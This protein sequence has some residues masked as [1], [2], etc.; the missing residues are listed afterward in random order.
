MQPSHAQTRCLSCPRSG[1]NCDNPEAVEVQSGFYIAANTSL[2]INATSVVVWQCAQHRSCLG[3]LAHGDHSC[4]PGHSGPLCGTCTA[5]FYRGLLRCEPCET[6]ANESRLGTRNSFILA[7]LAWLVGALSA[8]QYLRNDG[9]SGSRPCCTL[10]CGTCDRAVLRLR[11]LLR[12]IGQRMISGAGLVRIGVGYCQTVGV[13]RR[14][15]RVQWPRQFFAFLQALDK[16]SP[17][18]VSL[19]P[20]ECVADRSINFLMQLIATL[21]MPILSMLLLALLGMVVA[22]G[23]GRWHPR[24]GPC[25]LMVAL[26][27]WPQVWDLASWAVLL[28]YPTIAR[29]TVQAF[30]CIP[31]EDDWLLRSDPTLSCRTAEWYLSAAMAALGIA[32]YCIGIPLMAMLVARRQIRQGSNRSARRRLVHV[33]TRSYRDEVAWFME[34]VDLLRKFLL[35]GVIH[36]VAPNSRLQLVFGAVVGLFFLLLDQEL[37]PFKSQSCGTV[38]TAAHL[39]LLFTYMVAHL[40][41]V[42][43]QETQA[44]LPSSIRSDT[45][46]FLIIAANSGSF[47]LILLACTRGLT[48]ITTELTGEQLVFNDGTPVDLLPPQE[49]SGYHLF[50]SHVWAHGQDVAASLKSSLRGMLPSSSIFL[51]VVH[52]GL[53]AVT[54]SSTI[55]LSLHPALL[56]HYLLKSLTNKH[57]HLYAQDDLFDVS[58]LEVHIDQSDAV[59][60]VVTDKYLSSY[61]CRRELTAAM[62]FKHLGKPLILLRESD[63]AKGATT[64]A[65]LRAEL[66]DLKLAGKFGGTTSQQEEEGRQQ[67]QAAERLIRALEVTQPGV[68][69][70]QYHREKHLR[71]AALKT[72]AATLY[73]DNM[74]HHSAAAVPFN[75][76][77]NTSANSRLRQLAVWTPLQTLHGLR[78]HHEEQPPRLSQQAAVYMNSRY[79]SLQRPDSNLSY[80]DEVEAAL[81]LYGIRV[82]EQPLDVLP[83]VLLLCPDAF[84]DTRISWMIRHTVQKRS[85][86]NKRFSSRRSTS[87]AGT[88][89]EA[90]PL[91]AL[92][93]TCV[94]FA[95]YLDSCPFDLKELGIFRYLFNKWPAGELLQLATACIVAQSLQGHLDAHRTAIDVALQCIELGAEA[96][97]VDSWQSESPRLPSRSSAGMPDG[98]DGDNQTSTSPGISGSSEGA[99][100]A[101]LQT[102]GKNGHGGTTDY[103]E[104]AR[105]PAPGTFSAAQRFTADDGKKLAA[106]LGDRRQRHA[107]FADVTRSH[108]AHH[109]ND[110]GKPSTWNAPPTDRGGDCS[111]RRE[112]TAAR[113]GSMTRRLHMGDH[114]LESDELS[115]RDA[116]PTHRGLGSATT[117]GDAAAKCGSSR[118]RSHLGD[119]T[120][121]SD[122][123]SMRDAPPTHRGL[124][125]ATT[126]GGTAAPARRGSLTW[127]KPSQGSTTVRRRSLTWLK[128]VAAARKRSEG[129]CAD[130]DRV[131]L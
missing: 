59:L 104:P 19:V 64:V 35:T 122:E 102:M 118:R 78:L 125:S 14:L 2:G 11:R 38:Q 51:D 96:P 129:P 76:G 46:G 53:H 49:D 124:G 9:A 107:R 127:L 67:L 128:E 28:Q 83:T 27:N 86:T 37:L 69:V 45:W 58:K 92:Y 33:L 110:S 52:L 79:R 15:L 63:E 21:A 126:R 105:L 48:R 68:T 60:I 81:S 16:L 6:T 106:S 29:K 26:S 120:L 111:S 20:A 98:I 90:P 47:L 5:G 74:Q 40:F 13:F 100:Q 123:L 17:D 131:R 56:A 119:H 101:S 7:A 10:A 99:G 82:V 73:L 113:C 1:V 121:E 3:G 80:F 55:A 72:I 93:C 97:D 61:N 39:Q 12:L 62:R 70:I 95:F 84:A 77:S 65:R 24:E 117:R 108:P 103:I 41:F 50:L 36:F 42:G 44:S 115:M 130:A 22:P 34:G 32:F 18:V 94:P 114:T 54:H 25:K 23:A 43:D 109:T 71:L 112:G 8:C 75:C 4:A 31:Y 88:N 85:E 30:D 87:S 116:P 66:A 89:T 91:L 57:A